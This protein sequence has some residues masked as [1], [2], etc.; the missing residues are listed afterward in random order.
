MSR[1]GSGRGERVL[2]VGLMVAG[3]ARAAETTVALSGSAGFDTATRQPF[4]GLD[5]AFQPDQARGWSFVG[6]VGAAWGFGDQ[7]PIGV[8]QAGFAGVVPAEKITA[9]LG[10]IAHTELY[11]VDY[12][13]PIQFGEPVEGTFGK[14]GLLP[15]GLAIA[16]LGWHRDAEHGAAAWAVG[17]RI[18]AGAVGTVIPCEV[19]TTD[20]GEELCIT[21]KVGV[22]GGITGR[23]RLHEGLY[24]EGTIGPSPAFSLGYAFLPKRGRGGAEPVAEPVVAPSPPAAAAA[25]VDPAAPSA[26]APEASSDVAP[27]P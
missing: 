21:H 2:I 26:E 23:I 13:L 11:T 14:L 19:Q 8:L 3:S 4:A 6:R 17:A 22:L 7:R 12:A 10:L 25:A 9:R 15:G 18:G 27:P 20:P 16:E 5:L 24:L 1:C